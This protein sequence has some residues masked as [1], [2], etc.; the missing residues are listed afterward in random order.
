MDLIVSLEKDFKN[1]FAERKIWKTSCMLFDGN[2]QRYIAPKNV[3]L[4]FEKAYDKKKKELLGTFVQI[5]G[6]YIKILLHN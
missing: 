5:S 3:E 1:L 4:T 6:E 2:S